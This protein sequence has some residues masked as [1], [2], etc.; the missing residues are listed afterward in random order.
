[1]TRIRSWAGDGL[2][3]GA[4][5]TSSAGT[6]DTAFSSVSSGLEIAASGSRS[7]CLSVP[8]G[9]GIRIATWTLG[10]PLTAGYAMRFRYTVG[11]LSG[12]I[13]AQSNDS[14]GNK[15]AAFDFNASGNLRFST[16]AGGTNTIPWVASAVSPTGTEVRVE[17]REV[18]SGGSTTWALAYYLGDSSTPVQSASGTKA[19]VQDVQSFNFMRFSGAVATTGLTMDDFAVDDN[20]AAFIGPVASAA[21]SGAATG[22]L[23]WAGTAAGRRVMAGVAAGALAFSG[24]AAGSSAHRGAAPG[25]LAF[26]GVAAGSSAHRGAAPG[27]LAFS[28]AVA[29]ESPKKGAAPGALAWVGTAVSGA[30][31]A[32]AAT[33]A[34]SWAGAAAGQVTRAGAAAAA[35]S[36]AGASVGTSPRRGDAAGALAWAGQATGTTDVSGAAGGALTWAGEASGTRPADAASG[37]AAGGVL[38]E[39]GALGEAHHQGAASGAT[40]WTGAAS[41]SAAL[42]GYVVGVV[43]W[44]GAAEGVRPFSPAAP[45]PAHRTF[46]VQR[47]DRALRVLAEVRTVRSQEAAVTMLKD[48]SAKLDYRVDWSG[49]LATNETIMDSSWQVPAGLEMTDQTLTT[50]TATVWVQGGSEGV[51]YEVTNQILTN[52]GRRDERTLQIRVTDR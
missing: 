16:R 1:M 24:V 37:T 47:E 38:W 23:A 30:A 21:K 52:Q 27:G 44:V 6:G 4:L 26:S 19:A 35:T 49:W 20:G 46:R 8:D 12:V 25:A 50:N 40:S 32:G 34:T 51:M 14:G 41:G 5:T 15:S 2:S 22:A 18:T 39:T 28:G 45:T 7:P 13:I 9:T 43:E 42:G 17:Y 11:A 48:P 10:S 31:R 29:G 33:G 36:W 3:A